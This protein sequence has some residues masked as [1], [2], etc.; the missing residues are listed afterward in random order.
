MDNGRGE[1]RNIA[2]TDVRAPDGASV[3]LQRGTRLL[4]GLNAHR[5]CEEA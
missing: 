5:H 1:E 3:H 4:H 2:I